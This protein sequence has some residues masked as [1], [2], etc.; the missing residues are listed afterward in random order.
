MASKSS[1]YS[2]RAIESP[3]ADRLKFGTYSRVLAQVIS[4][5]DMPLT[6]G[7]FGPWGCG[8]TS[9]MRLVE[10]SLRQT[11]TPKGKGVW[12]VWFNPWHYDR[13]EALWRAL[14]LRVLTVFRQRVLG[15]KNADKPVEELPQRKKKVAQDLDDLQASLYREVDREEIGAVIV[16]W[17]KMASGAVGMFT[18][19]S[20]GLIPGLGGPLAK[21]AE[22]A[23]KKLSGED[24]DKLLSAVQRERRKVHRDHV[25]SMEQFRDN[26]ENV[27]RTHVQKA[28]HLLVVFIDDLDRCLPEKAIEV[29][30]AIKLFLDVPGCVFVIA[31]D[32]KVIEEGIRVKYKSFLSGLA[33]ELGVE[34]L[35]ERLP[36]SGDN[37][38]EKIVQLPFH[39]PPL[40]EELVAQFIEEHEADLP[41]GCVGIFCLGLERNPRKVKRTLNIF[42]LLRLL[43]EERVAEGDMQG[44]DPRLL[45]KIVIILI[46]WRDL[47][48]DLEEYPN[49]LPELEQMSRKQEMTEPTS[50]RKPT[51][52]P[53]EGVPA[54]LREPAIARRRSEEE[55]LL[56]R[57]GRIKALGKM[58][59]QGPPW[60]AELPS[61]QFKEYIYLARST[62]ETV[63]VAEVDLAER[64]WADLLSNDPTKI[65]A[66]AGRMVEAEKR[67]YRHQ[68][69][70]IILSDSSAVGSTSAGNAL[71]LL[72]DPRAGIDP[73]VTGLEQMEFCYVPPGIFHMGSTDDDEMA[74][75]DEKAVHS[76]EI[77]YGYWIARYPVTV[78]QLR[79]YGETGQQAVDED[80]LTELPNRPAVWAT[81]YEALAFC[82]WLTELF[83]ARLPKGYVVS[84]PSE[85]EW[86]KAA[87]G[88]EQVPIPPERGSF[89]TGL[90]VPGRVPVTDNPMTHRL[91]PWGNQPDSG[92]ANCHETGIGETSAVGCLPGGASPYGVED[93]SG[94]VWERTRSMYLGYP[95]DPADGREDLQAG[96]RRVVRGGAFSEGQRFARCACRSRTS[97][98]T[99]LNIVGFRIVVTRGSR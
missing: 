80:A 82:Q 96:G 43:A 10:Q 33:G 36:I 37:Y 32:R 18:R 71:A 66:V 6:I 3:E 41:E 24:V 21:M 52:D 25:R 69:L 87:R 28:G 23:Q 64:R 81:W 49:L 42:R 84:L 86:E 27:V 75:D 30:E 85:A 93:L 14:I 5:A 31:A 60:F 89:A 9:L 46:R 97:T 15:I 72:G 44:V 26:L 11:S 95:Y 56:E 38:L 90:R 62:T 55:P 98:S 57:Y 65:R 88:G 51:R 12:T 17:E 4:E 47:F 77:P 50:G 13:D 63:E 99:R 7:V 34:E 59:G 61:E 76:V 16:D 39:I 54:A 58:L 35:A 1:D 53:E 19:L 8:K 74:A 67:M 92:R 68:L 45:A 22:A 94:N 2:D 20:L 79:A 29:L 73:Q 40:R 48:S 78:A 91:Y 83:H 70:D